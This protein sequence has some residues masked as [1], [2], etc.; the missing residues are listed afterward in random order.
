MALSSSENFGNEVRGLHSPSTC[1]SATARYTSPPRTEDCYELRKRT[2][3]NTSYMA[4]MYPDQTRAYKLL[5]LVLA[6]VGQSQHPF[7]PRAFSDRLSIFYEGSNSNRHLQSLEITQVLLV[8]ALGIHIEGK[9][10]DG[11]TLP[12]DRLFLMAMKRV[13]DLLI[14]RSSGTL[15]IEIMG[16]VAFFLQSSDCKDDAHIYVSL[17]YHSLKFSNLGVYIVERSTF[18]RQISTYVQVRSGEG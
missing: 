9:V 17:L 7:D 3:E 18:S 6:Y 5:E 16:L 13:P 11:S 10:D 14:L 15:G 12:G 8:F 2:T 1:R 4:E